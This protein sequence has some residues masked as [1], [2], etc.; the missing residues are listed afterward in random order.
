MRSRPCRK[1]PGE[2]GYQIRAE[3]KAHRLGLKQLRRVGC[4]LERI[5]KVRQSHQPN[6]VLDALVAADMESCPA[7]V[8]NP[9]VLVGETVVKEEVMNGP[10]KGNVHVAPEM[11][12][13]DFR[14]TEAIFPAPRTDEEARKSPA[15]MKLRV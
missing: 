8:G 10:G 13:T 6:C 11:N 12:M 4:G 15:R 7:G 9:A 3:M 14:L 2:Q 1:E 5:A